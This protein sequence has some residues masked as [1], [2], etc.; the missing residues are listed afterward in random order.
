[1]KYKRYIYSNTSDKVVI[2][3]KKEDKEYTLNINVDKENL[4]CIHKLLDIMNTQ[5]NTILSLESGIQGL[6]KSEES[7]EYTGEIIDII[8]DDL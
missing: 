4:K 1:M 5:Y 6:I 8:D 3:D 7:K 2:K